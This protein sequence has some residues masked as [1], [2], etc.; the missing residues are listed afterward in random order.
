MYQWRETVFIKNIN[1]ERWEK[2]FLWYVF[3]I[4]I[5]WTSYQNECTGMI[6]KSIVEVSKII[7]LLKVVSSYFFSVYRINGTTQVR[8]QKN[9]K[10][11]KEFFLEGLFLRRVILKI[12]TMRVHSSNVEKNSIFFVKMFRIAS[13][14]IHNKNLKIASVIVYRNDS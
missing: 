9:L 8:W 3:N 1:H 7:S 5:F 10:G 13:W 11:I 4:R 2:F 14:N 6:G 12:V